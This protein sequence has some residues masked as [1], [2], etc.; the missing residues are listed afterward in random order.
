MYSLKNNQ[1]AIE[2]VEFD[3]SFK[4]HLYFVYLGNKQNTENEVVRYKQNVKPDPKIIKRI[5][6]LTREMVR[7]DSL[8]HFENILRE[9]EHLISEHIEK[10]PVGKSVFH[11]FVGTAKSLG[12]WGGDFVLLA[13]PLDEKYIRK[14]LFNKGLKTSFS[15]DNLI[16]TGSEVSHSAA[17]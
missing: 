3:P 5:S 6:N 9:H 16:N 12:A 13:T 8:S 2:S 15:F 14:Y 11:D 4:D 1:P 10:I 17:R 7:I